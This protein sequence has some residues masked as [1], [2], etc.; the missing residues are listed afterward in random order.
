MAVKV[1]NSKRNGKDISRRVYSQLTESGTR[2]RVAPEV[3][4]RHLPIVKKTIAMKTI[5]EILFS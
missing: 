1:V 3:V 4:V 5:F 2:V